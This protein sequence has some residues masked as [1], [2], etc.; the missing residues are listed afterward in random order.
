MDNFLKDHKSRKETQ[1]DLTSHTENH[2][3]WRMQ[4]LIVTHTIALIDICAVNLC[5]ISQFLDCMYTVKLFKMA[6][7]CF[8]YMYLVGAELASKLYCCLVCLIVNKII[9][10]NIGCSLR[11]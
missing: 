1:C 8:I 5:D 6:W 11:V 2:E 9:I 3:G 4:K 10:K 7:C